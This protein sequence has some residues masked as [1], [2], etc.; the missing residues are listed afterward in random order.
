M[1]SLRNSIG[2][3]HHPHITISGIK[4]IGKETNLLDEREAG[5]EFSDDVHLVIQ[6]DE[7]E[8]RILPLL[9]TLP[10]H[11]IAEKNG[12]SRRQIIRLKQGKNQPRKE[13]IE[14]IRIALVGLIH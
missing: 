6:P 9:N 4:Y 11:V 1:Q 2:L 14:K 12:L 5:L 13:T 7:W 8:I 3:L 10:T